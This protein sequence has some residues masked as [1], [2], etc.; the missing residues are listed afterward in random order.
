MQVQILH[1]LTA[2]TQNLK[3]SSINTYS[4]LINNMHT[5]ETL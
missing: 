3:K 5:H 4:V 2:D 1:F